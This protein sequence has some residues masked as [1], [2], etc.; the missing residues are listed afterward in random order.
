VTFG[1]TQSAQTYRVVSS[2]NIFDIVGPI[3]VPPPGVTLIT[4]NSAINPYPDIGNTIYSANGGYALWQQEFGKNEVSFNAET[5]IAS[6]ITT[7]DIS[8]VGGTPSQ[9]TGTGV[10]R[11]M[12]LRRVEPDFVQTGKMDMTIL[13]RKF[14]RGNVENS[15]PYPF[16]P[17]T[18]KIDLRV[19]HREIRIKFESNDIN[20]DFEMGR[21]L[22]TAEYGD[23]RP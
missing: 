15:G 10:N 7:C 17:D 1:A 6:S 18:G 14:A 5:A 4:L 2:E 9:D 8:W 22:I 3:L 23:E 19:E 12:H 13:G 16:Y 11:R 21:I 20:G